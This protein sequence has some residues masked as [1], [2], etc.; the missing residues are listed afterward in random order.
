M[1]K[2]SFAEILRDQLETTPPGAINET[3]G[4]GNGA[5]GAGQTRGAG[6]SARPAGGGAWGS[7]KT[8]GIGS[9]EQHPSEYEYAHSANDFSDAYLTEVLTRMQ[10]ARADRSRRNSKGHTGSTT[11]RQTLTKSIYGEPPKVTVTYIWPTCAQ[12]AMQALS[13][14]GITCNLQGS[15]TDLKTT[16]RVAMKRYHPDLQARIVGEKQAHETF[17]KIQPLF[18]VCFENP[19]RKAISKA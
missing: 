5:F 3:D 16:Y 10:S 18:D 11:A 19:P 6:S 4:A 12:L 17:L 9:N 7:S 14:Y 15:L 13:R 1:D 2:R 8:Q